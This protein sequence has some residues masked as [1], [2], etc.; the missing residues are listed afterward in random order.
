M[1]TKRDAPLYTLA[2]RPEVYDRLRRARA[3]MDNC[4]DHPLDLNQVSGQAS[5][6]RYHFI[7]LFRQVYRQTPHQYLT[8]KRI[9]KAKELLASTHLP[10]TEICFTVGF[11]SLGSF[12]TLFQRCVGQSPQKYRLQMIARRKFVPACFL[13]MAGLLDPA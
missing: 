9:E 10:V 11:Q 3:L 6:S 4:Y 1:P 8:R 2:A 12:S 13:V 7:R 5:F